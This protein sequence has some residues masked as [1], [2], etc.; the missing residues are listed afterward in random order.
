MWWQ[1][2]IFGLIFLAIPFGLFGIKEYTAK[3]VNPT[4]E[5]KKI[6]NQRFTL[7]CLFY[8][9]CDFFYMTFIV[10]NLIWRFILGGLIMVII[11]YNL[12]KVFVNGNDKF[13]FGLIQDFIVGL[14]LTMYLIYIIPNQELQ[15]IIIS[16]VSAV[17]GG[18]LT[19]IGV[20]WTIRKSDKDRKIEEEQKAK[21]I[22]F[23]CDARTLVDEIK[24]PIQR[25]LLS[26]KCIGTLKEAKDK[27]NACI[28]HQILIHNSDYSHVSVRGFRI[29]D[30]Y[31]IYD[32][33]QVLPKNTIIDLRSYFKFEYTREIKYVALILEDMLNNLY[34]MELNFEIYKHSTEHVIQINSGIEIKKSTLPLNVREI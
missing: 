17:Y 29:N 20:A 15:N 12:S 33:G 14:A 7:L 11:F 23:I 30:D 34:E 26:K 22:V 8:W 5:Q 3:K 21:P 16:I 25:F 18:L 28:L 24:N 27:N 31:H 4:E 19:L 2:L 6:A 1:W 32:I 13:K 9:L 10:K